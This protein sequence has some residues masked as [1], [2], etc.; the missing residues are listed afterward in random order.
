VNH[1]NPDALVA[2]MLFASCG[3]LINGIT[4]MAAGLAIITGIQ[5]L[6]AIFLPM[7]ARKNR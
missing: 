6:L 2:W 4:G 7:L 5:M 3:Y 1:F